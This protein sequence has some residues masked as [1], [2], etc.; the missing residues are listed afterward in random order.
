MTVFSAD[1]AKQLQNVQNH[2]NCCRRI[3]LETKYP[4]LSNLTTFLPFQDNSSSAST[5]S[6]FVRIGLVWSFRRD[7]SPAMWERGHTCWNQ[8]WFSWDK[9]VP[10]TVWWLFMGLKGLWGR[11]HYCPV[12]W[13]LPSTTGRRIW[14]CNFYFWAPSA[15][16]WPTQRLSISLSGLDILNGIKS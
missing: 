11:N 2:S 6:F 5:R 4:Y 9:A 1:A 16:T 13:V 15:R 14:D 7:S 12:C 8:V 3:Y 10:A